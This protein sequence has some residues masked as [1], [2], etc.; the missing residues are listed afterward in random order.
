MFSVKIT[1]NAVWQLYIYT[2][3]EY[4]YYLYYQY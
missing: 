4:Y 1:K 2:L 3:Q